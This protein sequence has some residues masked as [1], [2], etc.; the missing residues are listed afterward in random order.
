MY[1]TY[2][3]KV[4][5]FANRS[6]VTTEAMAALRV[7]DNGRADA[8]PV[9]QP[10]TVRQAQPQ[11]PVRADATKVRAPVVV[12]QTRPIGREVLR[13]QHVLDEVPERTVM[14]NAQRHRVHSLVRHA[15]QNTEDTGR[16]RKPLAPAQ[17]EHRAHGGLALV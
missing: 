15:A 2:S 5:P 7:H 13:V 3:S 10:F 1:A 17:G 9:P 14:R 11:A 6:G 8:R 16:R 12:V 4:K